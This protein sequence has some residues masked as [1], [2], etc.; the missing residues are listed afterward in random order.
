[1]LLPPLTLKVRAHL[2]PLVPGTRAFKSDTDLCVVAHGHKGSNKDYL[3]SL[4]P[5]PPWWMESVH[6]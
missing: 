5:H 6:S 3:L 2:I 1:M 4:G